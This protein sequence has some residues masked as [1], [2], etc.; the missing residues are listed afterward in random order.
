MPI[1]MD[2]R[3]ASSCKGAE[4]E[5]YRSTCHSGE[6][7]SH[8]QNSGIH[9]CS[10]QVAKERSGTHIK[11]IR[12][13]LDS[14]SR[15]LLRTLYPLLHHI[16]YMHKHT[17]REKRKSKMT[18]AATHNTN[19]NM[20][21]EASKTR[22]RSNFLN[23][24]GIDE[25]KGEVHQ[26]MRQRLPSR[27]SLLGQVNITQEPLKFEEEKEQPKSPWAN[28]FGGPSP[29]DTAS[30]SSSPSSVSSGST[31]SKSDVRITFNTEVKVVPIPMRDEY[32]KRVQ[33]RLWTTAEEI[34]LNAQRN[35]Y[36][37]A[38]EGWDWRTA[39]EDENMYRDAVSGEL[40]H[41]VHCVNHDDE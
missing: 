29:E 20:E 17:A 12:W 2:D 11:T 36:E 1:R 9:A 38:A 24:L 6:N 32:S 35:A 4:S 22:I 40:I 10:L 34:Q 30:L 25:K 27:G 37:F 3:I 41:P 39:L 19:I 18:S 26:P 16:R 33:H 5:S 28:F 21:V 23:K 7:D 15:S 8:S 31:G 14:R 13:I